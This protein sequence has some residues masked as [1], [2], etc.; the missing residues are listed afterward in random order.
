MPSFNS[1]GCISTGIKVHGGG[2]QVKRLRTGLG[3]G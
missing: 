3:H 2:I 1:G